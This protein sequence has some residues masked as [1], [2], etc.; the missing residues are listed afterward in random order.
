MIKTTV[1]ISGMACGMWEAHV[2][3]VIRRSFKVK[4]VTASH[5]KKEVVIITE[6]ALSEEEIKK[7]LDPTGYRVLFVSSEEYVKK[8]LFS[9]LKK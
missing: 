4:K 7:T 5:L 9:F 3:D 6:N 2:C 8:G 1:K